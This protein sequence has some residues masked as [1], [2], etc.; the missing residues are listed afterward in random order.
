MF[1]GIIAS[2]AH[3][4]SIHDGIFTMKNPFHE[5]LTRWESVAHDGAC[6]TLLDSDRHTYTFFAMEETLRVTNFGSKKIGDTFNVERSMRLGERIHGH[7]VSWH[8]DT[9]GIVCG[10]SLKSD[11]SLLL[12][13]DFPREFWKYTIY[14][15][16]I[17]LSG[18]SLTITE[19]IIRHDDALVTVSLIPLTQEMTNLGRLEVGAKLNIEC[20]MMAK[21][22]EKMLSHLDLKK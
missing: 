18:V 7:M 16:S 17:A 6:M 8:I 1:S 21:Y 15:W 20:D 10:R 19:S 12:S 2:E 5:I 13:V 4:L 9:V 14:K 3:I 22:V 11:G